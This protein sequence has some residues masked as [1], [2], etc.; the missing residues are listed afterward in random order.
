[1]INLSFQNSCQWY[2]EGHDDWNDGSGSWSVNAEDGRVRSTI[3]NMYCQEQILHR[4]SYGG[5]SNV[6]T[7]ELAGNGGVKEG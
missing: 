6:Q 7:E 4:A 3:L 1:M 2:E 5:K